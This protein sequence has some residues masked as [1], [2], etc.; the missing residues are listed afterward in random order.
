MKQF[1]LSKRIIQPD[2]LYTISHAASLLGVHRSTIYV[3]IRNCFLIP[4]R[5]ISGSHQFIAGYDLLRIIQ[6]RPKR[7]RPIISRP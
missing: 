5:D 6:K 1:Y 2:R 4:L 3:Y 7:G